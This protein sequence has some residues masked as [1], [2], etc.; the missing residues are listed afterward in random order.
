MI[1]ILGIVGSPRK[2][3]NT[4]IMVQETLKAAKKEGVATKLIRLIDKNIK[5]CDGCR[6][7]FKTKNC[8]IKDDLEDIFRMMTEADGII[9]GS[10]V[11]I[12]SITPQTKALIDRVGYLNIARGRLD[13]KN[14]IGGALVTARRSGF[15]TAL[16]QIIFF[17]LSARMIIP[18]AGWT[19]GVG[20]ERG[21]V[22]KD[23]E[24]LELAREL[25]KSMVDV[26][27]RITLSLTNSSN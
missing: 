15:L 5:P 19:Y 2:G 25:G 20:R 6:I 1:K 8:V 3:G 14:K 13:L 24:G 27:T 18:G 7:C 16:T 9:I 12:G 11:Y 21:Q 23:E 26:A 22:L 17:F 4:E 10:P